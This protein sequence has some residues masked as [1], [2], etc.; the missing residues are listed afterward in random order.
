MA[1]RMGDQAQQMPRVGLVGHGAQHPQAKVFG[2]RG[3][4]GVPVRVRQGDGL[5]DGHQA[6]GGV[7]GRAQEVRSVQIRVGGKSGIIS[8]MGRN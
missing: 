3:L 2:L 6:G 5:G 1:I 8:A 4:A 7:G